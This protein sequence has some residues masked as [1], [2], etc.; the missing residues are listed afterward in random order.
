[1]I[2][3][4]F[5]FVIRGIKLDKKQI[6]CTN[7]LH[8]FIK[9]YPV[10]RFFYALKNYRYISISQKSSRFDVEKSNQILNQDVTFLVKIELRGVQT[11]FL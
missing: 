10:A 9:V 1:M 2:F 6:S 5:L 3:I 4:I 8:K 7:S 11:L